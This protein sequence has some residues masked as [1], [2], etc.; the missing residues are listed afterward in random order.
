MPRLSVFEFRN[1]T[2]TPGRRDDLIALFER[3]F[4]ES[5]E[6]VGSRVV[7]TF[8]NLDDP[9]RFVWFRAFT[10]MQR[11]AAALDAFYTS[12]LWRS[13]RNEANACIADSDNVLLLRPISGDALREDRPP[14]G[15][16]A[17]PPSVIAV[18][19][20]FLPPDADQD[21]AAFF[22]RDIA[23]ALDVRPLAIFATEHAANSYPRLPVRENETVFVTL[24]R[25]PDAAA[26]AAR[27]DLSP[28]LRAEIARRSIAPPETL[29]LQPTAR[30][31][32]R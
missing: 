31:A 2:T 32:L 25:Y 4:V 1:Y 12:P 20:F 16:S 24:T 26:F 10:D 9:N 7:A 6:A 17:I 23:P 30:S 19:T 15:A 13:L 22:A 18:T 5:Q 29:R 8:R 11:R 21:F 27:A 14:I 28:A 3:E